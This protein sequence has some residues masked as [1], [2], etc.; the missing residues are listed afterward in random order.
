M[1]NPANIGNVYEITPGGYVAGTSG[2]FKQGSSITLSGYTFNILYGYNAAGT[3]TGNAGDVNVDLQ[4][5]AIPEPGT[6]A[7]MLSGFGMLLCIQRIRR[8]SRH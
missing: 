3:D 5:T 1:N 6:W 8:K 4:L 7:A 2:T